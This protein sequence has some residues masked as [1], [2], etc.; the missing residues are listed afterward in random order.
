MI[1]NREGIGKYAKWFTEKINPLIEEEKNKSSNKAEHEWNG[2][3]VKREVQSKMW[4]LTEKLGS[5]MKTTLSV[6]N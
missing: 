4:P 3:N 6:I 2:L 5:E 1:R